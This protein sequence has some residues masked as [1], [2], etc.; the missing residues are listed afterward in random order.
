M[1]IVIYFELVHTFKL[2]N[3]ILKHKTVKMYVDFMF[4]VIINK[5]NKHAKLCGLKT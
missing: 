4:C 1:T 3:V 2:I 5:I